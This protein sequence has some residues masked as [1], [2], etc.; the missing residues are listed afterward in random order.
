MAGRHASTGAII[1]PK[2]LMK[3]LPAETENLNRDIN[4]K[5]FKRNVRHRFTFDSE[6]EENRSIKSKRMSLPV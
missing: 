1:S 2:E 5:T 4:V 3:G 6:H